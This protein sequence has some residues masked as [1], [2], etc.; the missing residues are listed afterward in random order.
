[1]EIKPEYFTREMYNKLLKGAARYKPKA[2][3]K[4]FDTYPYFIKYRRKLRTKDDLIVAISIAYS[5]MPTMLDMYDQSEKSFELLKDEIKEFSRI[6][7]SLALI[8]KEGEIKRVL[9]KLCLATNNSVV[10][11]SKVLHLFYCEHIPIFD[12]RVRRAWNRLFEG[13][14]KI[15]ILSPKNQVSCYFTY[16]LGMLYWRESLGHSGVRKIEKELFN[17]GGYLNSSRKKK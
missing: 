10:G 17:Y 7:S 2:G 6:K 13:N 1:M 8:R 5:W 4:I 9:A 15:P 3:K 12:S 14:A 16:W 11:A